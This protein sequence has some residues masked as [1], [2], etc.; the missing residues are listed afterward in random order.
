[1]KHIRLVRIIIT[2]VIGISFFVGAVGVSPAFAVDP[3]GIGSAV[4]ELKNAG[5]V[6][7]GIGGVQACDGSDCLTQL[8]GHIIQIAL[9][10]VGVV[11]FFL[12]LYGG[13]IWMTARGD[14]DLVTKGKDIIIEAVIGMVIVFA[15][16]IVSSFVVAS[17]VGATTG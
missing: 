7:Y 17:I 6:P 5:S 8:I 16:Y 13:Y 12:V 11:F 1:M 14:S 10:V 9:S 15:A 4:K 2:F 3:P